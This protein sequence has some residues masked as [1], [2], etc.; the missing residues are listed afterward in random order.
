[1]AVVENPDITARKRAEAIDAMRQADG[2]PQPAG[3]PPAA[4]PGTFPPRAEPTRT[5]IG[6]LEEFARR[7]AKDY[8]DFIQSLR[9]FAGQKRADLEH[10]ERLLGIK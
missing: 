4:A 7:D 8:A 9:D 10:F 1:M 6:A 3:P 5:I 2:R